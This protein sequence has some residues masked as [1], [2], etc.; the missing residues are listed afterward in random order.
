MAVNHIDGTMFVS[1]LFYPIAAGLGAARAGAGLFTVFF[2][3]VGLAVGIGVTYVGRKLI[4][5][6]MDFFLSRFSNSRSWIQWVVGGPLLILYVILPY[7]IVWM[8][9]Y[10][11]WAASGWLVR[12]GL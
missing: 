3:P 5:L 2:I 4:Y 9:I 11:T 10:G 7:V 6:L 12:C 8:G 1:V